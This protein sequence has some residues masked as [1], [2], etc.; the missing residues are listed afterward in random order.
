MISF[1]TQEDGAAIMQE[2]QNLRKDFD[3]L[4][5]EMNEETGEEPEPEEPSAIEKLLPK[6]KKAK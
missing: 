4:V 1:L 2:I 5:K 3:Q 6:K